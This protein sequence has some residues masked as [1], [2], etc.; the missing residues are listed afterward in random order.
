MTSAALH[1]AVVRRPHLYRERWM[2]GAVSASSSQKGSMQRTS[3]LPRCVMPVTQVMNNGTVRGCRKKNS[4]ERICNTKLRASA[5]VVH[6]RGFVLTAG[7]KPWGACHKEQIY[8]SKQERTT[9]NEH[10]TAEVRT[11]ARRGARA[12]FCPS[13]GRQPRGA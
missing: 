7:S 4:K 6:G 13:E 11:S 12:R 5:P 9:L 3:E 8:K 10:T 2:E 1:Q